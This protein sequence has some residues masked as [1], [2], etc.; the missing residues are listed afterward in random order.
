MGQVHV[1]DHTHT[2]H[3]GV[4]LFKALMFWSEPMTLSTAT[5]IQILHIYGATD[6]LLFLQVDIQK[7]QFQT[8]ILGISVWQ[9][10]QVLF[11]LAWAYD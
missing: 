9:S 4:C 5:F 1:L 3:G 6:V 10:E 7:H 11:S 8:S 2:W